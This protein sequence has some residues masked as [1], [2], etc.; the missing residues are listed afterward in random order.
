MVQWPRSSLDDLGVNSS[1]KEQRS[2]GVA[3]VVEADGAQLS[4]NQQRLEAP[5]VYV[6]RVQERTNLSVANMRS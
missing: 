5:L 3:E 2:A 6:G 1:G 4:L